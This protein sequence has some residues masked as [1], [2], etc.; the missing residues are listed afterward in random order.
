MSA[1]ARLD[2]ASEAAAFAAA[3]G[4]SPAEVADLERFR[5]LLAEWNQR[6]NLVS[7][8]SLAD[9][10]TRH[11]L[12]CAQLLDLAPEAKAWVDIGAGA[13]FPGLVL[14][15]RLKGAPGAK[16]HLIE[17]Q[18]KKCRFLEAAAGAL[19]APAEVHNAR[20]EALALEAD[21]VTARAVAPLARLLDFARPYLARGAT[22]LFLKGQGAEGEIAE[23]RKAWRFACE[24]IQSRSDP[25]G[26]VLKITGVSRG[27]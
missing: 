5:A 17:S 22:G 21:I 7:D 4:A 10:W 19:A 18:A 9:F 14:A 3:S 23:A 16:V 6:L 20:A 12:D 15:I 26:R 1:A 25:S 24:T 11:A 27:R 13:G 8:A 2:L